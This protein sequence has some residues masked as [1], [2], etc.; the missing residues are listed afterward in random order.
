MSMDSK[1]GDEATHA[2][3]ILLVVSLLFIAFL[4]RKLH[5]Q[6]DLRHIPT[7]GPSRFPFSYIGAIWF[8]FNAKNMLNEG[9][10]RHRL[11]AFK[12][13]RFT[14]WIVII[15]GPQL[16]EELRKAPEDE[17]SYD[18]VC[19][20]M[21][22]FPWG[23]KKR[24]PGHTA[25]LSTQLTRSLPLVFSEMRDEMVAAF[26]DV[27]LNVSTSE[28]TSVSATDAITEIFSRLCNRVVVGAQ[29]CR[30]PELTAFNK[31]LL[32]SK[33]RGAAILGALPRPLHATVVYLFS[34]LFGRV[35]KIR[36]VLDPIIE[37]RRQKPEM[38]GKEYSHDLL[39]S[40]VA[41][42]SDPK[43]F[44]DISRTVIA[45]NLHAVPTLSLTFIHALYHLAIASPEDVVQPMREEVKAMVRRGGWTPSALE[46]MRR[47]DSFLKESM[48]LSGLNSLT[49]L[50]KSR[51]HYTFADG[52]HVPPG[53]LLA[54]ACAPTQL[55]P[56]KYPSPDKFDAFRFV[57]G[58]GETAS[59]RYQLSTTASDFLA[60]GYGRAA[61]PGRFVAAAQMKLV[62]A[63][64]LLHYDIRLGEGAGDVRP[65]DWWVGPERL[66]DLS[67]HLMFRKRQEL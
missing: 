10:R 65:D 26:S 52:T 14:R 41:E 57:Q 2:T 23:E 40:L 11:S 19:A 55:D 59:S 7:I 34:G 66:P 38:Y 48:R 5:R 62:L 51:T 9:Y 22:D 50:R 16:I 27:I 45:F 1:E 13:A 64:L 35:K 28:W 18:D 43:A 33:T 32:K 53:T 6:P 31:K 37:Q 8:F 24:D 56:S 46:R 21:K 39:S 29:V 49:M 58:S 15:T 60:W 30:D 67:I 63:H 54:A 44:S 42:S 61:C 17:M 20:E 4:A 36:K 3:I 47:V 25:L 12:V